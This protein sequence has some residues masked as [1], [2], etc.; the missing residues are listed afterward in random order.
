MLFKKYCLLLFNID[1]KKVGKLDY[2]ELKVAI[3][4]LGVDI[5]KAEVLELLEE[6]GKDNTVD[7]EAF[8]EISLNFYFVVLIL[9]IFLM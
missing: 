6:Y 5:K 4:S 9:L 3:R 1:T 7:Y 8:V 2:Y